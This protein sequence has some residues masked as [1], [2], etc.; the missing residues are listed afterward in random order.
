MSKGRKHPGGGHTIGYG[1]PPQHTRFKPG[2]SGNPRGRPRQKGPVTIDI[3]ALDLEL[4]TVML[5]GKPKRVPV[6]EAMLR[7]TLAKAA[8]G[9][10]NAMTYLKDVFQR[11]EAIG[12]VRTPN[13]GVL[14][15]PLGIPAELGAL[16][17]QTFGRPPWA[18]DQIAELRPIYEQEQARHA[19]KVKEW[20][21]TR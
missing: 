3:A 5:R 15:L 12:A 14:R 11:Y 1:R 4:V 9:D 19:Q 17:L 20:G 8:K 10:L 7:S 18:E 6:R 16:L 2:Q 13:S 21:W